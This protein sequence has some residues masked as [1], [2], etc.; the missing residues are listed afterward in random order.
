MHFLFTDTELILLGICF[1][2]MVFCY[3]A[4]IIRRKQLQKYEYREF[5][6]KVKEQKKEDAR[7]A[8][9]NKTLEAEMNAD[10]NIYTD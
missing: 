10:N 3:F 9:R 7:I 1:F 5:N 2:I 4:G 8:E 6:T